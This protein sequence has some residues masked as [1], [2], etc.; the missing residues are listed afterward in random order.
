MIFFLETIID[1]LLSYSRI[2][3]KTNPFS[4]VNL[5]ETVKEALSN[6]EVRIS[7]TKALVKPSELPVIEADSDQMVQLFQ[8]IIGNA[9]KFRRD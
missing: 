5:N 3:T 4:N 6:L 2:S 9:L 1:S 7:E 8:N